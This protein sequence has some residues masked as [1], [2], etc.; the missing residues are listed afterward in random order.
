MHSTKEA[1]M[2]YEHHPGTK[3]YILYMDTRAVGKRFQEYTLR[4]T[5]QYNVTYI[6]GRPGRVEADPETQN[7]IVWYEDTTS[8][9]TK[10]LEA[11]IVV[12]AQAMTPSKGIEELASILGIGLDEH[13]F[14]EMPDELLRPLDSNRP[15]IFTCGYAH[16]PRDIPDS[17]VQASG[18]AAR[19][20]EV[21]STKVPEPV[22]GGDD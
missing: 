10:S 13:G 22:A 14:M 17:V 8:G 7:P 6:R 16:S 11:D 20:A 3:S 2:A 15:G 19:V 9:E 12:L 21:I 18:A 5:E 4:A 1:I